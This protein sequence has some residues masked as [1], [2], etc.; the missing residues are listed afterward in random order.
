[1]RSEFISMAAPL[2]ENPMV[3]RLSMYTHHRG[4]NRLTHVKEVAWLSFLLGKKFSL[5][6]SAIVR[7]SLLHDLFYYDWLREGPRLHGFRHPDISLKNARKVTELTPVEV[8]IIKKHMWPLT[9][10]PPRY[11]ESFIVCI[12]DTYCSTRDYL[13]IKQNL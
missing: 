6:T 5:N 3:S 11:P 4:K 8:D 9:I 10:I 2:L 7:G 12:V 1:M 13:G